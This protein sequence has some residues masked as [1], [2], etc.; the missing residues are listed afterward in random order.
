MPD[1]LISASQ[2][3][4]DQFFEGFKRINPDV[5]TFGID[6]YADVEKYL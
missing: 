6:K 3:L 4:P 2:I 5:K 1:E